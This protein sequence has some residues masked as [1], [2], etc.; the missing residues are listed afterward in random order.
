MDANCQ[1]CGHPYESHAKNKAH[2][3]KRKKLTGWDE[4]IKAFTGEESCECPGYEGRTPP[5]PSKKKPV[6]PHE[7]LEGSRIC[8]VCK[9]PV[10]VK[11]KR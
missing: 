10:P 6:C 2:K 11:V 8:V 4:K 1:R 9:E 5:K 7:L 3:C